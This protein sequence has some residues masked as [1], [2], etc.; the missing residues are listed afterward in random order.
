MA[1]HNVRFTLSE[2]CVPPV[3]VRSN[4]TRSHDEPERA[5]PAPEAAVDSDHTGRGGAGAEGL[6]NRGDLQVG[7]PH[8]GQGIRV[9]VYTNT[10]PV[11]YHITNIGPYYQYW[12]NMDFS[13]IDLRSRIQNHIVPNS[14]TKE[15]GTFWKYSGSDVKWLFPRCLAS[16]R[17]TVNNWDTWPWWR[18]LFNGSDVKYVMNADQRKWRQIRTSA[19]YASPLGPCFPQS[20]RRYWRRERAQG[21][22]GPVRAAR[23]PERP[24]RARLATQALVQGAVRTPHLRRTLISFW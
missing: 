3:N 13:W 6:P 21:A 19:V 22:R 20:A 14:C 7:T 11:L 15:V 9:L 23:R 10:G 8:M 4:L 1:Y 5:V 2:C 12:T 18:T 16:P 17:L 24:P